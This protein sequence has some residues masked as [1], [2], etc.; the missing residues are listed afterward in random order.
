MYLESVMFLCVSY[1]SVKLQKASVVVI[2]QPAVWPLPSF[3]ACHHFTPFAS[4]LPF[5][6][7]AQMQ[8][9][10]H[11]QRRLRVWL[12]LSRLSAYQFEIPHRRLLFIPGNFVG[13][14]AEEWGNSF[15]KTV[16]W[17]D[18]VNFMLKRCCYLA[19]PHLTCCL[20]NIFHFQVQIQFR[21]SHDS[22][23]SDPLSSIWCRV[24]SVCSLCHNTD[25][26]LRRESSCFVEYS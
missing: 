15:T 8:T 19:C 1:T 3:A 25:L 14:S 9:H 5:S 18:S 7:S 4:W 20:N 21:I 22:G 26:F 23:A 11:T 16:Q 6:L 12:L 24:G 17:P 2:Q 10:T 13:R